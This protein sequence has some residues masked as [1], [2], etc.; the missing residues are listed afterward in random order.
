MKREKYFSRPPP[1]RVI[2]SDARLLGTFENQ[3]INGKT[4]YISTISRIEDGEQSTNGDTNGLWVEIQ[5]P[6]LNA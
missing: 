2:I 3:A 4:R 5:T 1:P 6:F